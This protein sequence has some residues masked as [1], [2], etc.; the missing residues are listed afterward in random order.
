MTPAFDHIE[1]IIQRYAIGEDDAA[2]LRAHLGAGAP[3]WSRRRDRL[4]G[5]DDAIRR[6]LR[7]FYD[8]LP[9]SAAAQAF[10][11]DL[12]RLLASCWQ[13]D[14]GE[15]IDGA[16]TRRAALVDIARRNE[17]RSLAWRQVLNI[18]DGARGG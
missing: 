2:I 1:A 14:A 16:S 6:A 17:G 11:R 7:R 3:R 8:G 15:G 5:R 10:S 13:A 9:V 18:L 4:E 12:D